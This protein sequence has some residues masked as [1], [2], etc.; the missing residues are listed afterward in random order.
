MNKSRE[1][2]L[3]TYKR[4]DKNQKVFNIVRPILMETLLDDKDDLFS[5]VVCEGFKAKA[6]LN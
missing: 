5:L 4:T 2:K 3:H 1:K 6:H